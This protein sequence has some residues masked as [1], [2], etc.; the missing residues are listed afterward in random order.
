MPSYPV[1]VTP[2]FFSQIKGLIKI[3]NC[4]KFDE[5]RIFD[6]QVMNLQNFSHHQK[7]P[8]LGPFGWFFGHNSPKY[9]QIILKFGAVMQA[10]N[11][12]HI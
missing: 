11:L 4:G 6:Y 9:S 5:Y 8:F 12:H 1:W 2:Q 3:H 10:N 7:V